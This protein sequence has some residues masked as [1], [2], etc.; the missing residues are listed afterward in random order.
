M[1]G[2]LSGIMPGE[3]GMGG[4]MPG[5][6]LGADQGGW[7]GA[8]SGSN[9]MFNMGLG[10]LAN[11]SGHYGALG[12]ALG[13]GMQQGL[14]QT[15]LARQQARQ[16]EMYELQRKR[17]E[18]ELEDDA[19]KQA[20]LDK[21]NTDHPEYAGLADLDPK[22]AIKI[23]YPNLANNTA[24]PY[25]SDRY[26]GGKTYAFNHRTGQYE[27]RNLGGALPNK[28]DPNIQ[29]G[30]A[31]AKAQAGAAW[32]PSDMMDGQILTEA[33]LAEQARGGAP[34]PF[35]APMQPQG[36]PPAMPQQPPQAAIPPGNSWQIPPAVQKQRDDTRMQ[37]LLAEQQSEG[38]PGR[39]P[40]LDR[41]IA[42]MSRG[43]G[44]AGIRIPTKAEQAGATEAAKLLAENQAKAQVNL[45]NVIQE[46]ENTIKLIDDLLVSPGYEQAVG[47]SRLLGV[48]NIPGTEAK[49]FD[50]R[51]EQLKG[52]QFLQAYESLK[53]AGAITDIE[54]TKAGN[55]ISRMNASS[56]E[57]EFSKAAK[58]FQTIIRQGLDRAKAKAGVKGTS[59]PTQRKTAA[60]KTKAPMKGQKVD[61]YKFKG[62]NPADPANWEKT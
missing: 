52:K 38:G 31:G 18:K 15:Q 24:D 22:A 26:I 46:S 45:P 20:A 4:E 62:G 2:L 1:A 41:E 55:A 5:G 11:N 21:F 29:G 54:G 34:A 47:A 27:E 7:Q 37:I 39:N 8:L 60:P 59:E 6:I 14:Q 28:D 36:M 57:K 33:Q 32:K 44:G 13:G 3:W 12:P 43:S 16:N 9:P 58:E 19:R 35:Q 23:A 48:Q 25:F 50:L 53:G 61:G 40:E 56:S 51:L 42:N 17:Y 49:D 30:V 10:I